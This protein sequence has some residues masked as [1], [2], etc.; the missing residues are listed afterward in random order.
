M[1]RREFL[2]IAG[3]SVASSA[4]PWEASAQGRSSQVLV[5]AEMNANSLD[6]HTVGANRASYGLAMM[7]YD[8]L[9][10]FGFKELP[11]GGKTYDYFK[12]EPQPAESWQIAPDNSS[13][14]FKLRRD[15]KFHDG[16]PM[17]AK[18]VKWSFDRFVKVGGF[19]QRQMEQ[20]S[21]TDVDQFEAIDD[22]T[23]RIK[24]LR[25][26]KLTL[27]SLA[28]VVPSIYNSEL[29][30]K[31]A[32]AADPWALEWTKTNAAGGGAYKVD[33]FK[34][35]EQV[36]LLRF[37]GWKGGAAPAFERAMYRS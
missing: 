7:I 34:S 25:S 20:C 10:Q 14:T 36:V 29:C 33:S 32:S 16:T 17:T 35:G 19:P 15:V 30:K 24:F 28:I 13:V 11:G 1:N 27:P 6:C 21:L 37:D 4:I 3:L 12:L 8:R 9:L 22:Y 18:D 23:F 2:E 31:N 26:D 5:A